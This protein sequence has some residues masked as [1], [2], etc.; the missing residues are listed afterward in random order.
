MMPDCESAGNASSFAFAL[1]AAISRLVCHDLRDAAERDETVDPVW[2]RLV[3]SWDMLPLLTGGVRNATFI[4]GLTG[5]A[6]GSSPAGLPDG[7]A[8]HE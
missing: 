4:P 5:C 7:I 3:F 6:H 8:T 2:R 1:A